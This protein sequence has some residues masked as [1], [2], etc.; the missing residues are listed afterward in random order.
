[1]NSAMPSA[2]LEAAISKLRTTGNNIEIP[3]VI[4]HVDSSSGAT[5]KPFRNL[6]TIWNSVVTA[7]PELNSFLTHGSIN[8]TDVY[9]TVAQN[10]IAGRAVDDFSH[11]VGS[12]KNRTAHEVS[13]A[14]KYNGLQSINEYLRGLGDKGRAAQSNVVD[15]KDFVE[16]TGLA[17]QCDG[18][19][20][21][22]MS[23]N[24]RFNYLMNVCGLTPST[25]PVTPSR[26]LVSAVL[27]VG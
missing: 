19:A 23:Q 25:P 9:K 7:M 20:R 8:A 5:A 18:Y 17:I 3:S 24:R 21:I 15:F 22:L 16:S 27:R 2:D 1:M 14:I 26:M 10:I 12:V 6:A 13:V 11:A 4:R